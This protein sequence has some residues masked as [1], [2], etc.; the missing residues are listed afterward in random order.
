MILNGQRNGFLN[1][2]SQVRILTGVQKKQLL[3]I[4]AAVFVY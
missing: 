4:L 3:N 1:R 2:R